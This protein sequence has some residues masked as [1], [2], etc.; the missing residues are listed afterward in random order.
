MART[1][2]N[3]RFQGSFRVEQLTEVLPEKGMA[4]LSPGGRKELWWVEGIPRR[5]TEERND[6]RQGGMV[7][8]G[9][10]GGVYFWDRQFH[11]EGSR[12]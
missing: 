9:S 10:P 5:E 1:E 6:E 8:P 4:A 7:C 12:F 3:L 2:V 11:R